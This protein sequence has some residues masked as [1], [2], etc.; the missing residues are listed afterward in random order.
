MFVLGRRAADGWVAAGRQQN[1]RGMITERW[2]HWRDAIGAP[3]YF[4]VYREGE[5]EVVA[6]ADTPGHPAVERMGRLPRD[7]ARPRDRPVPARAS[8]T[9]RARRITST[10]IPSH[11]ITPYTVRDDRALLR[12]LNGQGRMQPV[13]ERQ[14]YALGH[15]LRRH[16]HHRRVHRGD[17]GGFPPVRIRTDVCCPRPDQLQNEVGETRGDTRL[18][19]QYL[20]THSL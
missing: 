5:I 3:V 15:G 9:T 2:P 7:G 18:L 11:S 1:R 8:S 6:V 16:S 13:V 17:D 10:V 20:K 14:E 19:Y 12:R 4:A